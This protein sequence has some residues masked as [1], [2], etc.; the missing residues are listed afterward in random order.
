M[1]VEIANMFIGNLSG[2]SCG[3]AVP[4]VDTLSLAEP[5]N[6]WPSYKKNIYKGFSQ[7][8]VHS[9]HGSFTVLSLCMVNLSHGSQ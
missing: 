7:K 9:P 4:C 6:L 1:H 2:L 5:H 8:L 3:R